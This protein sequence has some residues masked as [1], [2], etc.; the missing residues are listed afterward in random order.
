MA[1]LSGAYAHGFLSGAPLADMFNTAS[2]TR[3]GDELTAGDFGAYDE[4]TSDDFG[5][6]AGDELAPGELVIC[7]GGELTPDELLTPG[8]RGERPVD[9]WAIFA[10]GGC[11]G[12]EG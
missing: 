1:C 8:I 7:A 4:P 3:A 12:D 10:F 2:G 6:Y 5:L 11:P 9:E